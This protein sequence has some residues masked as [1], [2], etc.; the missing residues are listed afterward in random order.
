MP[1]EHGW[2]LAGRQAGRPSKACARQAGREVRLAGLT[3]CCLLTIWLL[4]G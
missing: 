3:S 2:L 4:G 1:I